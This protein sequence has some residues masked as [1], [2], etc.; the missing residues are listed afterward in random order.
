MSFLQLRTVPG[1]FIGRRTLVCAET[2]ML[3]EGD[4]RCLCGAC[5]AP[6]LTVRSREELEHVVVK[7]GCGA[8]NQ[9]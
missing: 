2:Q 3:A 9:L 5:H 6:L 1:L 7:C 8:F 4:T